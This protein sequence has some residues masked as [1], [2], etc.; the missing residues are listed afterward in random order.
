VNRISLLQA[1]E[2]LIAPTSTERE[3]LRKS[4][5]KTLVSVTLALPF[6]EAQRLTIGAKAELEIVIRDVFLAKELLKLAAKWEPARK[7]DAAFKETL[8]EDLVDLLQGRRLPYTG[9]PNLD[10]DTAR[11][12]PAEVGIYITRSLPTAE[13]KK[14][15][16]SWKT[17]SPVPKERDE[18][19]AH[20]LSLL[21]EPSPVHVA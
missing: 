11:T 15:L 3:E 5:D 8:R 21:D 12:K 19:V 7:L 2:P 18:I 4:L 13:A 17:I 6:D 9:P 14:L 20:L 10:L 16:K 1:L